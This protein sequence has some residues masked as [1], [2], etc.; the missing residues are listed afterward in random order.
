MIMNILILHAHPEPKSFSSA[1]K[2]IAVEHFKS[3]GDEVV[4]KDLY[5]M[6][7]NPIGKE[8]DFQTISNPEYFNYMKEQMNA[9][10]THTFSNELQEEIDA[11]I[12]ADLLLL[13]F[14]LWWTSMPAILK[15]WFDRVIAFGMAYH[16]RDKKYETGAFRHKKV[17][18]CIT[19]GGSK[20]AYSAEGEHGDI[21][22]LLHHLYHGLLFFT[23]MD[24][25]PS[26][27]AWKAHL[28]D[29]TTLEGYIEEYKNHLLKLDEF[30]PM[31]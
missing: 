5:L 10:M 3:K 14:P 30:K 4:V 2:N 7:F 28:V 31:F 16:P 22:M 8:I 12:K 13:N 21:N 17:M 9:F 19:T 15:G 23:G 24:V 11:L 1:L 18:C 26:Y 6:K 20:E 29:S 27:Y 25:L